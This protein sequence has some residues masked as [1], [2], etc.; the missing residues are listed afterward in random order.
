MPKWINIDIE[1]IDANDGSFIVRSTSDFASC[2][3]IL[4][5]FGGLVVPYEKT[6]RANL[7][8]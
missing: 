1:A 6:Y 2:L 5:I 3:P 4:N 7:S 8:F